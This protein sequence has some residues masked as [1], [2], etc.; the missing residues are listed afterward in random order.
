MKRLMNEY[1]N[2]RQPTEGF[3]EWL[4][5]R[6]LNG[7]GKLCFA[8]TLWFTWLIIW[9]NP[10]VIVFTFEGIFLIIC[11]VTLIAIVKKIANLVRRK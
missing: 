6:K 2:S 7:L 11:L 5:K 10:P 9:I 1:K 3:I 8:G 4:L